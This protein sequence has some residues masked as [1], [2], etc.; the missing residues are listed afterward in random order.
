VNINSDHTSLPL[1]ERGWPHLLDLGLD[2]ATVAQHSGHPVDDIDR[3]LV[4]LRLSKPVQRMLRSG[5]PAYAEVRASTTATPDRPSSEEYAP[6]RG[7]AS[8]SGSGG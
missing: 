6:H 5:S 4:V 3:R 1:E 8:M 2:A 7:S